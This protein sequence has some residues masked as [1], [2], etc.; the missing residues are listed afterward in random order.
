MHVVHACRRAVYVALLLFARDG[1]QR[2]VAPPAPVGRPAGKQNRVGAGKPGPPSQADK[3]RKIMEKKRHDSQWKRWS[4]GRGLEEQSRVTPPG[5]TAVLGLALCQALL[6]RWVLSGGTSTAVRAGTRCESEPSN[7]TTTSSCHL[8]VIFALCQRV[9][10][11]S[12]SIRSPRGPS[13]CSVA[14]V[15]ASGMMLTRGGASRSRWTIS[16]R[17]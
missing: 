10:A 3:R 2:V 6:R 17:Q 15:T 4:G 7:D 11:A 14:S 12:K 5:A 8:Q 13:G 9:D 16:L 1:I